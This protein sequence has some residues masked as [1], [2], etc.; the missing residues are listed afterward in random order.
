MF[1]LGSN[2]LMHHIL[3]FYCINKSIDWKASRD[4][5]KVLV[6][7]ALG[8]RYKITSYSTPW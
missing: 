2:G 8:L 5:H 1:P 3:L 4:T 7:K 6:I